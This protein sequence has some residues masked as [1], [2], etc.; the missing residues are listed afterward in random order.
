[1]P[2]PRLLLRFEE[3]VAFATEYQR[4]MCTGGAFVPTDTI[5]DLREV[6]ELEV[7]LAWRPESFVEAAEVVY[8]GPGPD[9]RAGVAVQLLCEI[10]TLREKLS[11]Y[12]A[13]A[14]DAEDRRRRVRHEA[15]IPVRVAASDFEMESHSRDLSGSGILISS[16]GNDLPVGKKVRVELEDPNSGECLELRGAVARQVESEG[17]VAALGIHFDGPSLGDGHLQEF[18]ERVGDDARQRIGTGMSGNIQELG[19]PNLIQMLGASCERGTLVIQ[20]GPEEGEIV[21]D[22]GLLVRTRLG[23]THGPKAFMRMLGWPAGRFRFYAEVAEEEGDQPQPLDAALFEG[24]RLLDEARRQPSFAPET[25][26]QVDTEAASAALDLSKTEE[27]VLEL[28]TAGTTVRR[29]LDV[30]PDEDSEVLVALHALIER[31]ILEPPS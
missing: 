15:R 12:V 19:L 9:G 5:F 29:I 2:P 8:C 6:V 23:G 26:L 3:P 31:G 30:I 14:E 24:L 25:I 13:D 4:N 7:Q 1:M 17:T 18:V 10:A 22:G 16:D 27:A 20:R 28:A 21:F 11:S